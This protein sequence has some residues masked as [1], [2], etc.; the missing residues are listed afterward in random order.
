MTGNLRAARPAATRRRMPK[1]LVQF[2]LL[3][4]ALM[5]GMDMPAMASDDVSPTGIAVHHHGYAEAAEDSGRD[6]NSPTGSG[7]EALHHHHCPAGMIADAAA[8]PATWVPTRD[9]HQ[10]R[11][12][13]PL[14]SRATAPPTQPPSA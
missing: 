6:D 13:A 8:V 5:A 1:A 10:S 2:M 11:A 3:I 12:S 9:T 4:A 7:T 14:A